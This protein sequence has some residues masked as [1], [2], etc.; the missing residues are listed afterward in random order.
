MKRNEV[1]GFEQSQ[2]LKNPGRQETQMTYQLQEPSEVKLPKQQQA[3]INPD[4]VPV[5]A[6]AVSLVGLLMVSSFIVSF[7]GLY[8]ASEW[9]GQGSWRVSLENRSWTRGLRFYLCYC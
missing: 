8:D 5:L 9:T 2:R 4:S 6:T 7:S 3:R 1:V